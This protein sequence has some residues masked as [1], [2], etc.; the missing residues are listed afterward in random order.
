MTAGDPTSAASEAVSRVAATVRAG[1]APISAICVFGLSIAMTQP[2]IGLR[3]EAAE[4]TGFGIG[5]S[6]LAAAIGTVMLAPVLPRIVA[7]TGMAP[8]LIGSGLATALVTVLFPLIEDYWVWVVLRMLIGCFGT[9]LFF[10]SEYWIVAAAPPGTR[11]R[12]VAI[13]AASLSVSFLIGPLL[14]G[15]TGIAGALPFLVVAAITALGVLPIYLGRGTIPPAESE[16]PPTVGETLRFFVTDPALL[17][18]VAIFGVIEFGAIALL[19][20]WGVRSGLE[21]A[22][23]T[24]LMSSFAAGSILFSPVLG[25]LADRVDRRR[26]LAAVAG[27][28]AAAPLLMIVAPG[29]EAM[30]AVGVLWGAAAVGLYTLA[31]TE[32]GARYSGGML[33]KGNAAVV[34]AYGLGAVAAPG[35][36][37][38]AM[39]LVPPDGL[40]LATAAGTLGYLALTLWRILT[41]PRAPETPG[42]P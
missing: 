11:G 23:A 33:A 4:T 5:L 2:L 25:W 29:F 20:V 14:I 9:V 16:T 13:Y 32:L 42:A 19:P 7:R 30:L 31:L 1:A 39:D 21:T 12:V 27:V 8:L 3:L 38:Q 17:W 40:L 15:W 35:A 28:S 18:G 37:G 34:L 26:L 36:L 24:A 41:R 10:G 6:Q 22:S